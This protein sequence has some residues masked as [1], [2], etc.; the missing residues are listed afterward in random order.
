MDRGQAA[1]EY[2]IIVGFALAVLGVLVVVYYEHESTS[3]HQ[4]ASTQIDRIGKK[5]VDSAEEVYFLGAPS[6]P[7]FPLMLKPSPSTLAR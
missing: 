3:K 1:I 5:L 2:L 6:M 7:T 4:I